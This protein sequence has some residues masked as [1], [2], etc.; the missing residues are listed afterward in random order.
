MSKKYIDKKRAAKAKKITVVKNRT[1]NVVNTVFPNGFSVGL[2]EKTSQMTVYGDSTF[3]GTINAEKVLINGV[4][5]E[6][7]STAGTIFTLTRNVLSVDSTA[8]Y[9][10]PFD[11]AD[12]PE[13]FDGAPYL[14]VNASLNSGTKITTQGFDYSNTTSGG[15]SN[16]DT[17]EYMI[18][19]SNI[20]ATTSNGVS[21][22]VTV[23]GHEDLTPTEFDVYMRVSSK[24][25]ASLRVNMTE[26]N[27][28]QLTVTN[29]SQHDDQGGTQT[30]SSINVDVP[31]K[32]NLGRGIVDVVRSFV[33]QKSPAGSDGS[34]GSDGVD[35]ADGSDGS[36]GSDAR[37]VHLTVTSGKHVIIYD[38]NGKNPTPSSI[39]LTA[40][41]QNVPAGTDSKYKFFLND[42]QIQA[43]STTST[44]TFTPPSSI[45]DSS[46]PLK[47]EVELREGSDN[48]VMATDQVTIPGVRDGSDAYTIILENE[49][50][51]IPADSSGVVIDPDGEGSLTGY[52]NSGT[53]IIVYR[54]ADKLTGLTA[55]NTPEIGEYVVS[56]TVQQGTI[57][58]GSYTV[59]SDGDVVIPDHSSFTSGT[60]LIAYSINA[61]DLATITKLQSITKSRRG[62]DG[63][64][65]ADGADGS[66]G[67][68]GRAV[69]LATT[70][71][72][73]IY[74]AAETDP[75]PDGVDRS[76]SGGADG[77]ISITASAANIP[78]GATAYYRFS[79][80]DSYV[81]GPGT[82]DTYL[83]VPQDS[84]ADMPDKIEV[85]L[86]EGSSVSDPILAR[87]QITIFGLK[88]GNDGYSVILGNESHT[89]P[90]NADGTFESGAF[91]GSG[92][93]L[94][95]FKGT[96]QLKHTTSSNAGSGF[97]RYAVSA[98]NISPDGV[99]DTSSSIY[100]VVYGD[101]SS[102]GSNSENN[103][104][105]SIT[106]T[107]YAEEGSADGATITKTQTFAK[108]KRG[109]DGEPGSNGT[110]GKS[111]KLSVTTGKQGIAYNDVG[112]SPSPSSCVLTAVRYGAAVSAGDSVYYRFKIDGVVQGSGF[113]GS[114]TLSY[115]PPS[116]YTD[117][118]DSILV[119]MGEGTSASDAA[120]NIVAQDEI[121][122][123]GLKPGTDGEDA[124]TIILT[125]EAHT[126]PAL[127]TTPTDAVYT[128]SGTTVK[129]YK[130]V[131][132]L[133]AVT[134]NP[135]ATQFTVTAEGTNVYPRTSSSASVTP[136][137]VSSSGAVYAD[138]SNMTQNNATIT[139]TAQ[140]GGGGPSL[141]KVQTLSKSLKGE[142]GNDGSSPAG[143][144]LELDPPVVIYDSNGNNPDVSEIDLIAS[145]RNLGTPVN[146]LHFPGTDS[147]NDG[148]DGSHAY[149]TA[150]ESDFTISD[151]ATDSD[152]AFS[153]AFW[154]NL[155][156]ASDG[157]YRRIFTSYS[158]LMIYYRNH[159]ISLQLRDETNSQNNVFT[160]TPQSGKDFF[161]DE[162][163]KWVHV[164]LVYTP[165][166]S[167]GNNSEKVEFY[168]NGSL[169]QT[170]VSPNDSYDHAGRFDSGMAIGTYGYLSGADLR[171]KARLSSFLFYNHDGVSSRSTSPPTAANIA[172]IY[173]S[174]FVHPDYTSLAK[175]DDLVMYLKCDDDVANTDTIEDYSG[176]N[177][178][179]NRTGSNRIG[180]SV[181]TDSSSG[182][183]SRSGPSYF[184]F[185]VAG[186]VVGT[187]NQTLPYTTWSSIPSTFNDFVSTP[188]TVTVEMKINSASD[189]ADSTDQA[190][191]TA[192]NP[193]SNAPVIVL[194]NPIH[195]F[196]GDADGAVSSYT[197][198]GTDI[199]VYVNGSLLTGVGSSG[200][201]PT[202]D[203][204]TFKVISRTVDPANRV[205]LSALAN[206]SVQSVD[207]TSDAIRVPAHAQATASGDRFSKTD[208]KQSA[209]VTYEINVEGTTIKAIQSLS[210]NSPGDQGPQGIQGLV[211]PAGPTGPT[212][213]TGATGA[214]GPAGDTGPAGND[215]ADVGITV[216]IDTPLAVVLTDS[217][218]QPLSGGFNNTDAFIMVRKNGT[219]MLAD[220][221][222]T[223][224]DDTFRFSANPYT[225]MTSSGYTE[226]TAADILAAGG[227]PTPYH[228]VQVYD[229]A[230]MTEDVVYRSWKLR[231]RI[232]GQ[233]YYPVVTQQIVKVIAQVDEIICNIKNPVAILERDNWVNGEDPEIQDYNPAATEIQVFKNSEGTVT[234]IGYGGATDGVMAN[235]TYRII[236]GGSGYRN[237]NI[238]A[239]SITY[240]GTAGSGGTA[241]ASI[242]PPRDY[243]NANYPDPAVIDYQVRYKD[244]VGNFHNYPVSQTIL[245]TTVYPPIDIM[246]FDMEVD[247]SSYLIGSGQPANNMKTVNGN[248]D[249]K[250]VPRMKKRDGGGTPTSHTIY[251]RKGPGYRMHPDD[252]FHFNDVAVHE[253][254][255]G[256][257]DGN[258]YGSINNTNNVAD[259]DKAF[260]KTTGAEYVRLTGV[261]AG[262]CW[263]S[264]QTSTTSNWQWGLD[265]H[266]A[267]WSS[268]ST[269]ANRL[270]YYIG[271]VHWFAVL[272][273]PNFMLANVNAYPTHIESSKSSPNFGSGQMLYAGNS[274]YEGF[275]PALWLARD[276]NA[277][278]VI[279][280][281]G[282][283]RIHIELEYY[284]LTGRFA[285]L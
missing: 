89:I 3:N 208:D 17:N 39:T 27:T 163:G 143:I 158:P 103:D 191:I 207:G 218:G 30:F 285:G 2:P 83:Y 222:G 149:R 247:F 216:E 239:G 243:S 48:T 85:E 269:G 260:F 13:N 70:A 215:G 65:G 98:T 116:A 18:D 270:G 193:G 175:G 246:T 223:Q 150:D 67:A 118:P 210:V 255:D 164:A 136:S 31:F 76:G 166:T 145:P 113:T 45:D 90:A 92:T 184:T 23:S 185:K 53:K 74:T 38:Q 278:D 43:S 41:S 195:V 192:I 26:Q 20:V 209:K 182:L 276:N 258:R 4:P 82:S 111:V 96:T 253:Y 279:P 24:T 10:D 47:F 248:T 197:N 199:Q 211:G 221:V 124:Y 280:S 57:T 64:D 60:A 91:T 123:F 125:N 250:L 206:Y 56:T 282:V 228:Y 235:N 122:M 14:G 9:S 54:G 66:D 254:A 225:S 130:G 79:K 119:E 15:D 189:P 165:E 219:A 224:S 71:Q 95:V 271:S 134:S 204:G 140:V 28:Q 144:D 72:A 212:G 232:G 22:S 73:I 179:F 160:S 21:L 172:T 19:A 178:D 69:N 157:N 159:D 84:Y 62:V 78:A 7:A 16:I 146:V 33:I 141:V 202:T 237:T 34:D 268:N 131:T 36:N 249:T 139:Y 205:V 227:N 80:N 97:Y 153:V 277:T 59:D 240:S 88:P 151:Q 77:R 42:S 226:G 126:L 245:P 12:W 106:F 173:N 109:E 187:E 220:E 257:G 101:A 242:G 168:K 52:E 94:N 37:A 170:V 190:T 176:L 147:T 236:V 6:T 261:V 32:L 263:W 102:A 114:N 188:K 183:K 198:S 252:I 5:V 174:G 177:N 44:Y 58:V 186:T 259:F 196:S 121:T 213:A 283:L 68:A 87:D 230:G 162:A 266:H 112:A 214:T 256:T 148:Y 169:W 267:N 104:T 264:T 194:S 8:D 129:V 167:N 11:G 133:T 61:E 99:P 100:E 265:I 275:F 46:L 115:T 152:N 81:Q 217:F 244:T 238:T 171:M 284:R 50:H 120:S 49:A 251:N 229:I 241:K 40:T 86:R 127:S 180:T 181:V 75:T 108:S 93:T 55:G 107:I 138:H 272:S 128:G 234:T 231:V 203:S 262:Q 200:T 29:L 156:E 161:E 201:N 155:D 132:E 274:A 233:Y 142:T 35:G 25:V 273:A 105:A 154:I 1:G 135:T 281:D 63:V 110:D 51:T 117:M 137:S